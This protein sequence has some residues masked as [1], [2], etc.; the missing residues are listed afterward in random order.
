VIIGTIAFYISHQVKIKIQSLAASDLWMI[1][2][3][4]I[5]FTP[6]FYPLIKG[7]RKCGACFR[8]VIRHNARER[9][10]E[11]I[12]QNVTRSGHPENP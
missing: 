10:N 6:D 12:A 9:A 3:Q 8:A 11:H 1:H 2:A 5:F 7:S 4:T